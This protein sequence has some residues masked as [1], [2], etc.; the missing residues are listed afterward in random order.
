M[1]YMYGGIYNAPP[2][3]NNQPNFSMD[4]WS[5]SLFQR[6]QALIE[7]E[8][9][10]EG[11]EAAAPDEPV[12]QY[13]WDKDAFKFGLFMLG[14]QV[15][16]RS[17][18]YGVVPQ[19]GTLTGYG[20][21]YQPSGVCVNT[22]FFQFT[23]PLKIGVDCELIKITPDY[24]SLYPIVTKYA[25]ELKEIDTSIR[26]AARNSRLAYALVG[27]GD[28]GARTMKA[29]R[30]RVINGEDVIIDEKL[31]RDKAN[32][33]LPPWFQFDRDVKNN[34]ILGDL[35]DARRTTLVD[36]YRE[37]GVRMLDDKKE[38][39]LTAEVDAGNAETFIRSEVWMETLKESCQKVN[40]MFGTNITPK[41]NRP[42]NAGMP[43][44]EVDVDVRE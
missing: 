8:G 43:E 41:V 42:D 35:L 6:L 38:R 29:I 14:Y 34:Y 4:Y 36:F 23:K 21:Q 9:L 19:P 16:F 17:K 24:S 1:F 18:T 11:S 5:Q 7:F 25:A 44:E 37:I 31:L 3:M 2:N 28:K 22:P 30:E 39:M 12:V 10:P 26:S 40:E 33:D 20:L 32:P 27:S 13:A 15:V